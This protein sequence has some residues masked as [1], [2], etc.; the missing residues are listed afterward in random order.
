MAISV[1]IFLLSGFDGKALANVTH[2]SVALYESD[3]GIGGKRI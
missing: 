3:S 1:S 2:H